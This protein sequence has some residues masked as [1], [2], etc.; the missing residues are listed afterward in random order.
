MACV[1]LAIAE[2]PAAFTLRDVQA[3]CKIR[4]GWS[5]RFTDERIGSALWKIA[6]KR[7]YRIETPGIGAS[8]TVYVKY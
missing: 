7:G 3:V 8:P 6:R 5:G 2:C 1:Q 4:Y